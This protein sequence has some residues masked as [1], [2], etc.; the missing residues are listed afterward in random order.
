MVSRPLDRRRRCQGHQPGTRSQQRV[1][2][3]Q[4][5]STDRVQD[6]VVPGGPGIEGAVADI[7]DS[8]G[9]QLAGYPRVGC[10]ADGGGDVCTRLGGQLH[11]EPADRAGAP[12]NQH[13]VVRSEAGVIVEGLPAGQAGERERGGEDM[14]N[15]AWPTGQVVSGGRHVLGGRAQPIKAD[16]TEHLV[17][18]GQIRHAF[19]ARGDDPD[20]SCDGIIGR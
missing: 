5:F 15:L 11:G 9:A 17:T 4:R 13:L 16:Q 3:I 20:I 18:S 8:T 1:G 19:A 7:D 12:M 2:A 6:D 10:P 14:G